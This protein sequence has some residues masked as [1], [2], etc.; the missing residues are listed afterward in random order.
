[1]DKVI[2]KDDERTITLVHGCLDICTNGR[3]AP[4]S[5]ELSTLPNPI[6][7]P[8]KQIAMLRQIGKDPA[9]YD[10]YRMPLAKDLYLLVPNKVT[11]SLL[12]ARDEYRAEINAIRNDPANVERRRIDAMYAKAERLVDYPGEYYGLLADAE[13]ALKAW[14]AKYPAAAAKERANDLRAKADRQDSLAAG[15]LVYDADGWLSSEEQERRAAEFKV[16]AAELRA[17]ADRIQA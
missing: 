5:P 10:A 1:M 12:D 11:P 7:P 4:I 17:E 9:D 14:T 13:A 6:A 2:Y 16:R 8:A 15:A 3:Q